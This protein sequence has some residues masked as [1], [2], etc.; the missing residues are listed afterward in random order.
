MT[1]FNNGMTEGT[2]MM[3]EQLANSDKLISQDQRWFYSKNTN[4]DDLDEKF[5][6]YVSHNDNMSDKKPQNYENNIND[7]NLQQQRKA[8]YET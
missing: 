1:D 7:N 3:V 2:A 5:D 4:D 6:T 8:N